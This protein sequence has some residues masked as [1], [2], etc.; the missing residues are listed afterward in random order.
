MTVETLTPRVREALGVSSSY[1]KDTIPAAIRRGMQRLLRDYHFPKSIKTA[2]WKTTAV[3]PDLILNVGQQTFPLPKGFKKDMQLIYTQPGMGPYDQYFS[4]PLKKLEEFRAPNMG[5]YDGDWQ[6]RFY[7]LQG[8]NFVIDKWL[9][10]MPTEPLGLCLVYESG[11]V[12]SNEAWLCEDF[13]DIVY[14]L[15]VYRTAAEMRKPEV[16]KAYEALWREEQAS[17]A[18]YLNEL[19]FDNVNIMQREPTWKLYERYP[20]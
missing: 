13:E 14:M 10:E 8:E 6:A 12:A 2:V 11:D 3:P 5:G 16:M 7:W 4:N 9:T 20:V 19:E 15:T 17:I 1:D 18:I